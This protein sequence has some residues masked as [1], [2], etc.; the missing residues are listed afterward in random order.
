MVRSR[1]KNHH[2]KKPN[3]SNYD[4]PK[5]K[6]LREEKKLGYKMTLDKTL[7]LKF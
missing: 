1:G 6:I 3:N 2:I 4:T 5:A 7:T